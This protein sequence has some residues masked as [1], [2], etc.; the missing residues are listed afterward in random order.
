PEAGAELVDVPLVPPEAAAAAGDAERAWTIDLEALE[1]AFHEGAKAY[2]LCNPHNPTGLPHARETLERVAELAA[3]YDVLVVSDEIHGA[4]THSDAEFV[5]YLSVSDAARAS[6]VAV[7][8]ASKAFNIPGITAAW[9]IPG[10]PEVAARVRRVPESLEHQ[11][12]HFGVHASIAGFDLARE[13]L[14]ST[15]E[16]L[17]HAR[18]VLGELLAEHLPEVVYHVPRASYLAWLDFRAL[19]WGDSPAKRILD[20]ARVALTPGAAFGASGR[21]Y[22]R[23]ALA[24]SPDVLEQAVRCIAALR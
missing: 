23:I 4:L 6:G 11:T 16:A 8:S 10:S 22:A 3:R 13:W 18:G 1:G 21:G 24:S 20:E 5:P 2:L 12:S 15:V 14:A 17:E 9:W 19:G 7:T